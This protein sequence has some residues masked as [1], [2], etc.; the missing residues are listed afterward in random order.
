MVVLADLVEIG[1][2]E[3][4]AVLAARHSA[5]GARAWRG[6]T[7]DGAPGHPV[8]FDASLRSAFGALQGDMGAGAVLGGLGGAVHL[9]PLPGQ[10]ARRDLD[11]PEDWAA[12]RA[13]QSD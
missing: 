3:I 5:P 4:G 1:A 9:V 11:T 2:S 13:A 8:L 10:R 12:Y 7:E 6:A